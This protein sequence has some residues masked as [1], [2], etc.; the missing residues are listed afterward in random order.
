MVVVI[1]AQP[2]WVAE[3]GHVSWTGPLLAAANQIIWRDPPWWTVFW[4]VTRRHISRGRQRR[5]PRIDLRALVVAGWLWAG[6][7]EWQPYRA[8]MDLAD[9]RNLSRAATAFALAPYAA[10][11]WRSSAPCVSEARLSRVLAGA[12]N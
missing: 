7:Y 10:K 12:R 1:V 3:G 5:A 4:R 8:G 6:R 11:T 2:G 9:G